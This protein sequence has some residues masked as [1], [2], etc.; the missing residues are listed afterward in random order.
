MNN[1]FS[2][3]FFVGNRERLRALFTGT[4]PI[5]IAANG[6]MQRSADTAYPFK[7]DPNFWYLTGVTEPDVILVMDK[8]KDYLIVPDRTDSRE[9]FDGAI[10]DEQLTRISGIQTV[11]EAKAG[12]KQLG[13]RIKKVKH[14]ATLAAAPPYIEMHG[15]YSNPARQHLIRQLKDMNEQIELLDLRSHLARMRCIKQQPELDAIQRAIDVTIDAV[16]LIS[17][18]SN[19]SKYEYEFEIE[20]EL[21]RAFRKSG[22]AGHAF[23]PI[24]AGGKRACVLHNVAN[25]APLVADELLILDVGAEYDEYAADIT[26]TLAIGGQ[27]S[28]RQELVH[29]AVLDVQQFA[30]SLLKPGVTMKEYEQKVEAYMGEKQR[31]LGLIKTI[32]HDEVRRYYPHATS[33]F[34][35]LDVHDVGNYDVPLTPGMVLTCEPGIYIPEEGIGVR[36]EDDVL[37]TEDGNQVLSDRLPRGLA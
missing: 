23:A 13:S 21:N 8:A 36:I 32:E 27:P 3:E 4:A 14:V 9:A 29:A 17:R 2:S 25:D 20:A 37:I 10:D 15:I 16:K 33:H 34:L 5:V 26:R 19:I 30:L 1:R 31:E 12:W 28:R 18:P 6:L 22:A 7:Q 24:I 11:L 35:G